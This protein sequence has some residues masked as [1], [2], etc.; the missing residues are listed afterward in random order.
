M[1]TIKE[2]YGVAQH[3]KIP[4]GSRDFYCGVEY[5][6]EDIKTIP[7]GLKSRFTIE[8][9]NSLRNNGKEFKTPPET[10]EKALTSFDLLHTSLTLGKH[11]FSDRTS[12]HVHVNVAE[13]SLQQGRQLVLLYAMLEPLF[14]EYVGEERKHS[15][16]CVPLN[17]TYIPSHYKQPLDAMVGKWHKY[18]ALNIKPLTNGEVAALG[19]FEFRHLYGT[20][21]KEV[22][23]TWLTVLKELYTWIKEYPDWDIIEK[24]KAGL[25]PA[26]IASVSVPTL[27]AKYPPWTI[28]EMCKDTL[29]D[30]KLSVGGLK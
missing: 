24:I 18:T 5:E 29:L 2:H 25:T 27:A 8:T 28:N 9:D 1:T 13:L 3:P 6:I 14:F 21:N 30:V 17:Y 20:N 10:Y 22:F 11:P 15:I 16:F 19:T 12:I 23:K 7:E 4:L 26:T